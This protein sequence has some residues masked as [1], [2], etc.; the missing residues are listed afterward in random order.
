MC[1]VG[2]R[3]TI[4]WPLLSAEAID[5]ATARNAGADTVLG[6]S[7]PPAWIEN[8][9]G[10]RALTEPPE[11]P[12]P[13]ESEAPPVGRVVPAA[14]LEEPEPAVEPADVVADVVAVLEAAVLEVTVLPV[15]GAVLGLLEPPHA[16]SASDRTGSMAASSRR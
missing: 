3:S 14:E 1:G 4:R 10:T 11:D 12:L 13:P 5:T 8:V 7:F 9:A 16:R 15:P 2:V 6:V